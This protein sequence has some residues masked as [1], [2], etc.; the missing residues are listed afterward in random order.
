[1]NAIAIDPQ[2]NVEAQAGPYSMPSQAGSIKGKTGR[3]FAYDPLPSSLAPEP[4]PTRN[5]RKAAY[6]VFSTQEIESA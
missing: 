6:C 3:I 4:Q 2:A 1:M 5:R